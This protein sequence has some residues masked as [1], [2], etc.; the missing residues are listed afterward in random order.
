MHCTLL[1][2]D[3]LPAGQSAQA[4]GPTV[5][6]YVPAWHDMHSGDAATNVYVPLEHAPHAN[7]SASVT[8]TE[9]S[10]RGRIKVHSGGLLTFK[11]SKSEYNATGTIL[12][13]PLVNYGSIFIQED[14]IRMWFNVENH[15]YISVD[16]R[17]ATNQVKIVNG[18]TPGGL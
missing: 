17:N 9:M 10:R 3:V 2:I 13:M 7:P 11:S 18:P 15:A 4:P 16:C 14:D 12:G 5:P 1:T 8:N 6:V